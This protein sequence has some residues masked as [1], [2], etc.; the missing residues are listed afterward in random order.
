MENKTQKAFLSHNKR[1]GLF[2]ITNL[3]LGMIV[4]LSLTMANCQSKKTTAQTGNTDSTTDVKFKKEGELKFL[5]GK[6]DKLVSKIDIEVAQ[7]PDEQEQGLMYRHSM[8]DSL[9][10]LF[11]FNVEEQQ[12]FWM[13]NTYI[14]LDIIYV[15][16]KKEIVS[17]AQNCKPLSEESIPSEGNAKYVV[18]VNGGYTAKLGLKKGDKIDY[19]LT[20]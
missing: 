18:E 16:G 5:D 8:A 1:S 17:I 11:I 20:K 3:F 6:S 10:M 12:S 15:N 4:I 9:G 13:K 2:R 7:T 19:S 14:P